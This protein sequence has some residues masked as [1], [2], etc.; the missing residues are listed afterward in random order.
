MSLL[1]ALPPFDPAA[2]LVGV[3]TQVLELR[4]RKE[5]INVDLLIITV[6]N[7]DPAHAITAIPQVSA[8]GVHVDDEV[9][10]ILAKTVPPL[11]ERS[12]ELSP[13]VYKNIG[14]QAHTLEADGFPNALLKFSVRGRLRSQG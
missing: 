13:D 7:L 3:S 9:S 2:I 1:R 8:D 4:F 6:V 10:Q 11:Q 14:L 5:W 12:F